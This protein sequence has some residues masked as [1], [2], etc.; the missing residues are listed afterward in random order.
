MKSMRK[1]KAKSLFEK[2]TYNSDD[3]LYLYST[4]L[5]K[6]YKRAYPNSNIEKICLLRGK[7][8]K[9]IPRRIKEKLLEK[10]FNNKLNTRI[11]L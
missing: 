9:T 5:E 6:L 10:P 1:K 4:K 11:F 8:M 2:S 3:S 7:Y